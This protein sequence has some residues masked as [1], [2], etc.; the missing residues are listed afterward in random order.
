MPNLLFQILSVTALVLGFGFVVFFH[1][2][3]HFL[4]AKWVGIRVEQF[5]IGF[6]HAIASWRKGLGFRW[7]S[8]VKEYEQLLK[9]AGEGTN[10]VDVSALGETEYRFNWM[11]L[12]GYVKMLGQ[13]DLNP[14]ATA[15]DPR[16]FNRKSI[17]ARMVV[18]A[19]GVVMNVILAAILFMVL[20]LYGYKVA[21]PVVAEVETNSPAQEAGL[22][23]GDRITYF[24]GKWQHDYNSLRLGIALVHEGS[25]VTVKV[26]HADEPGR[27]ESLQITPRRPTGDPNGFLDIGIGRAAP[28]ALRGLPIKIA[29]NWRR[30]HPEADPATTILPGDEIIAVAGQTVDPQRD[31]YVLDH[32]LQQSGGRPVLVTVKNAQGQQRAVSLQ[33]RFEGFF[34]SKPFNI[35][36]MQPRPLVASVEDKSPVRG[37]LQPGDIILGIQMGGD[38]GEIKA[39]PTVTEFMR[40]LADAGDRSQVVN[41]HYE[42]DGK[43]E[44][45]SRHRA[46]LPHR[47][48][49]ARAG[50]GLDYGR[51]ARRRGRRG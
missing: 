5:A 6:G 29:E 44:W 21:P 33:S 40:H 39:F 1:E 26:I 16:A 15:D 49:E 18:V 37:K 20:F 10:K 48:G 32:A 4:A 28:M 35:A 24:D 14:N 43:A 19:A 45:V 9:G 31:Y 47:A 51:R 30:V 41:I 50:R 25:P 11:P 27:E 42:R 22:R 8:S 38:N 3:G 34:G 13:D 7:G 23:V 46:R 2:L 12:G 36:G 17:G